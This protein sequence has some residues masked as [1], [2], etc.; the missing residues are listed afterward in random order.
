MK[1]SAVRSGFTLLAAVTLC[2]LPALNCQNVEAPTGAA[3]AQGALRWYDDLRTGLTTAKSARRWVLVDCYTDWCHWCKRLDTD[4][5]QNPTVAS[6]LGNH[7]VWVKCNTEDE[8]K[9]VWVKD[10]YGIQGYPCILILDPSG[11]EKGRIMG[12]LPPD[13]FVSRVAGIL[14]H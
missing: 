7:F 6:K 14:T 1:F 11:N 8:S 10:R 3:Q 5:F 4:V 2:F 9:G 13:A 12:Y